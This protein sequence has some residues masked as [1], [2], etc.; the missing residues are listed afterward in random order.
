MVYWIWDGVVCGQFVADEWDGRTWWPLIV[1]LDLDDLP[2][3]MG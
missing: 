3:V 1:V 2:L